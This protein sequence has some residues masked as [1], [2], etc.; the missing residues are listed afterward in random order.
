MRLLVVWAEAPLGASAAAAAVAW[1]VSSWPGELSL[2]REDGGSPLAPPPGE[3]SSDVP[4]DA[5]ELATAADALLL[6]MV[7]AGMLG[8][9]AVVEPASAAEA[10]VSC[11][12]LEGKPV[13][14]L[15][16][17]FG[18][19]PAASAPRVLVDAVARR[20]AEAASCGI[21]VASDARTVRELLVGSGDASTS[22]SDEIWHGPLV[23]ADVRSLAASGRRVVTLAEDGL[24]TPLAR[25]AA[26]EAG[27]TI[28]EGR[29]R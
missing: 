29:K 19:E 24:A 14:V 3:V 9:A 7:P 25:D 1:L 15:R 16:S 17:A 6:P 26:S 11:A 12:L 23:E 28:V 20:L 4:P 2:V 10:I 18:P 13:C 22:G 5:M 21:R 8:R 27:V